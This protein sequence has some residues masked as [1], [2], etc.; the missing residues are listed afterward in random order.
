MNYLAN[1]GT[2]GMRISNRFLRTV[3]FAKLYAE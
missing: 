1:Y 2:L 3:Q